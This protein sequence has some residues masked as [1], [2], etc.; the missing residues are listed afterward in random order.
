MTQTWSQEQ[1]Q[2]MLNDYRQT[3]MTNCPLDN[4][5]LDVK[6]PGPGDDPSAVIFACPTCG[7]SFKSTD[8]G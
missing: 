3:R 5:P 2:R 1:K 7:N 6:D 4:T 8:V